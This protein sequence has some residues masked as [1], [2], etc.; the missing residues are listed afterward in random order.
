[1]MLKVKLL[2]TLAA[3]TGLECATPMMPAAP[4][5]EET[6]S[7]RQALTLPA[8]PA[9]P[10][11][12]P[13]QIWEPGMRTGLQVSTAQTAHMVLM[14]DPSGTTTMPRVLAYGFNPASQT[15]LFVFSMTL[16]QAGA[17]Q[18]QLSI[19]VDAWRAYGSG[20]V[21]TD[22][23]TDGIGGGTPVPAPRPGFSDQHGWKHAFYAWQMQTQI[24]Q[25]AGYP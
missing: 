11:M 20:G 7:S 3:V 25:E 1:M 2:A 4:A 9:T 8:L 15:N 6:G 19:D 10:T 12:Q 14:R 18:Q 24:D 21:K 13:A 22:T 23:I 17:F 5:P 16:A